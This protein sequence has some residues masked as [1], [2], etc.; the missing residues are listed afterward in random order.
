MGKSLL[1]VTS[2]VCLMETSRSTG[3]FL[4]VDC[5]EDVSSQAVIIDN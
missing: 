1:P 4:P 5:Y 2:C 3:R